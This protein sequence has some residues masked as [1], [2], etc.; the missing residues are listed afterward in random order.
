MQTILKRKIQA[1]IPSAVKPNKVSKIK[2]SRE[3]L[4]ASILLPWN[5][6]KLGHTCTVL[7]CRFFV[8]DCETNYS[9]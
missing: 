8:K 3:L 2:M 4:P 7:P 1:L 6:D 5:E 9:P